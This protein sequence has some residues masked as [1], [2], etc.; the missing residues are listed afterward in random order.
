MNNKLISSELDP[1]NFRSKSLQGF[2][3]SEYTRKNLSANDRNF[4]A[5][6]RFDRLG[7]QNSLS[8][9]FERSPSFQVLADNLHLIA[10]TYL[11]PPSIIS[12]AILKEGK[13]SV[14]NSTKSIVT[15]TKKDWQVN[16][17]NSIAY[18]FIFNNQKQAIFTFPDAT[19]HY[20]DQFMEIPKNFSDIYSLPTEDERKLER[21][22]LIIDYEENGISNFQLLRKEVK[23]TLNESFHNADVPVASALLIPINTESVKGALLIGIEIYYAYSL[24]DLSLLEEENLIDILLLGETVNILIDRIIN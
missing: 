24:R 14:Y 20:Y 18:K 19:R 22:K 2:C 12:L 7:F 13:L 1:T 6:P 11:Y 17:K 8:A 23:G 21:K 15:R 9:L 5:P 10:E 16:D 3:V 4:D